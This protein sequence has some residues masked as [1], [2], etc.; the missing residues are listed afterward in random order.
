MLMDFIISREQ[1][2][3]QKLAKNMSLIKVKHAVKLVSYEICSKDLVSGHA[4]QVDRPSEKQKG[5]LR[6]KFGENANQ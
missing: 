2:N 1:G 3:I 6:Q 4:L 5:Y